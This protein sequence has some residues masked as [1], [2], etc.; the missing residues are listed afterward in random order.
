MTGPAHRDL[1]RVV[2][3]LAAHLAEQVDGMLSDDRVAAGRE[4][5]ERLGDAD[6]ARDLDALDPLE[7]AWLADELRRRWG[8]VGDV[9]LDPV[10][11]VDGPA[12]GDGDGEEAVRLTVSV[13]GL[14]P[15]W[16]VAWSGAVVGEDPAT[17][18]WQPPNL[19][20]PGSAPVGSRATE[21]PRPAV[22]ARVMGRGPDGRLILTTSWWPPPEPS[23]PPVPGDGG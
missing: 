1:Q 16:T 5:L 23:L 19:E 21:A 8:G 12:V 11:W 15:G 9:L 10:A 7:A 18:T 14:D 13:D 22:T 2:A 4:A 6:H 3:S 17:A 20:Q